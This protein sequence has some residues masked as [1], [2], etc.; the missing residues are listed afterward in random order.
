MRD[1]D[2]LDSILDLK[3]PKLQVVRLLSFGQP[4]RSR[5][6][7]R[8]EE[9]ERWKRVIGAYESGSVRLEGS[10]GRLVNGVDYTYEDVESE[11][12]EVN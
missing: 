7:F 5:F 9:L 11:G 3:S 8:D 2:I 1:M 4:V 6:K 10:A 12:D